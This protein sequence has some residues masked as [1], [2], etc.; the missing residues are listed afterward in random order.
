MMDQADEL[1][2]LRII[3]DA[4]NNGDYDADPQQWKEL[5]LATRHERN[6]MRYVNEVNS[7]SWR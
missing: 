4:L 2:V 7:V 5:A 1:T 6:A 3:A